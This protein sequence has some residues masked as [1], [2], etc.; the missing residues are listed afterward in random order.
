MIPMSCPSC[1]RRGTIP[2]DRLNT[3]MHC[4]KCDAVFFMDSG[5]RLTLGEPPTEKP[6]VVKRDPKTGRASRDDDDPL[7]P[8]KH[9]PKWVYWMFGIAILG[10]TLWMGK[11]VIERV[12]T[13]LPSGLEKRSI[14]FA[15][16]FI[17][18]DWKRMKKLIPDK[19]GQEAMLTW[20][21]E[22]RP[23]YPNP[24]ADLGLPVIEYKDLTAP[25]AQTSDDPM[26]PAP[27]D[28]EKS[29]S[30][31]TM[32]EMRI[33]PPPDENGKSTG[34]PFTIV[35]T[36]KRQGDWVIDGEATLSNSAASG[37]NK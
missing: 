32:S 16:A 3:R 37:L 24:R 19:P 5:G 26:A 23:F 18:K 36:W 2:P 11:G 30:D 20:L 14:F 35:L 6:K 29:A 33:L 34:D 13:G 1:G 22:I 9:I 7:A 31:L 28:E 25:A 10:L 15:E 17:D 27:T 12:F 8:L 4:K 21:K